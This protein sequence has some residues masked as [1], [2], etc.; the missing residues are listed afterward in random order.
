[1]RGKKTG[2]PDLIRNI[3]QQLALSQEDLARQLN[4]SYATINRWENVRTRPSRLAQSQLEAFCARM[5]QRG[6]LTLPAGLLEDAG[7]NLDKD[8][9]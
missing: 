8:Q 3:R 5:V 1:M 9:V 4:V 2:L 7:L 6:K